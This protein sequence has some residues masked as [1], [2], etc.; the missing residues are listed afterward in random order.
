MWTDSVCVNLLC[1]VN[2]GYHKQNAHR[3]PNPGVGRSNRPGGTSYRRFEKCPHGQGQKKSKR[4][5][6]VSITFRLTI[7]LI[8]VEPI[9]STNHPSTAPENI[10]DFFS[11]VPLSQQ[12]S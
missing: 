10:T 6:T 1:C 4:K 12:G 11:E 5:V 2:A 7:L 9:S 3:I 8:L